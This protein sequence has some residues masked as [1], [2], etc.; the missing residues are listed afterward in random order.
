MTIADIK[1]LANYTV[2][3]DNVG[4]KLAEVV[5]QLPRRDL[6]AYLRYL[7]MLLNKETV[8]ITSTLPLPPTDKKMLISKFA[9]KKVYFENTQIG[10]GIRIFE[11]DTIVDL[12]VGGFINQTIAQLKTSN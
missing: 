8:I 3:Q 2:K 1:K 10:D 6:I 11:N 12:T 5:L 7:K 9:P 4:K